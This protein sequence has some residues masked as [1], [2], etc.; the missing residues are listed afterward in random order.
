MSRRHRADPVPTQR[1]AV[2]SAQQRI[3]TLGAAVAEVADQLSAAD[4]DERISQ[5]RL[6][7]AIAGL[8]QVRVD[9]SDA[10]RDRGAMTP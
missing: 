9:L 5:R 4:P 3:I 10:V 7:D 2:T 6:A 8:R 1:D